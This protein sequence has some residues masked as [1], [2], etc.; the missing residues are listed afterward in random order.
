MPADGIDLILTVPPG[1]ADAARHVLPAWFEALKRTGRDFG[2]T[3]VD[4][5]TPQGLSDLASER[6]TVLREDSPRRVWGV[7]ALRADRRHAA[8][9][10]QCRVR[11]PVHAG[12]LADPCSNG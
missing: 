9:R 5:G 7:F 12:R 6:V 2:I 4:D 1:R 3:L 8:N 10:R 11:V